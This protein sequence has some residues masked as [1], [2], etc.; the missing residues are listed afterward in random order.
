MI[1]LTKGQV[2]VLTTLANY[3]N[4]YA[5]YSSI[6]SDG[7]ASKVIDQMFAEALQLVEYGFVYN[8]SDVPR[9]KTVIDD[10]KKNEGREI[11]ILAP[12]EMVKKMF[13]RHRHERWVN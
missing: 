11:F 5:A 12:T 8:V 13:R 3:R 4:N 6:P 2:A 9:F 7:G 10:Y 1:E